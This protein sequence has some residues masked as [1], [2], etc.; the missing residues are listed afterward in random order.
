[1]TLRRL[2][3]HTCGLSDCSRSQALQDIMRAAEEEFVCVLLD[4]GRP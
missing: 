3:Q 4:Q 2:L 1:V